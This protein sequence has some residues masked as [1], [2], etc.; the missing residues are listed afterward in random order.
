MPD[1]LTAPPLFP[2]VGLPEDRGLQEFSRLF[3]G[4]WVWHAY[5]SRLGQ[6]EVS[7]QRLRLR[8]LSYNPGRRA[9]VTGVAEWPWAEFVTQDPFAI[10]LVRGQSARLFRYPED[11]YLPGLTR[12]R[13]CRGGIQDA[14]QVRLR[15]SGA[16]RARGRCALQT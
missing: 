4:E 10:E 8:Q 6:P 11:P 13:L 5:C 3:D 14:Q 7:P 1:L 15:G 12:C 2:Q 9:I 16:A